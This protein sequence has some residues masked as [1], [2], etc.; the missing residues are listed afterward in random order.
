[1]SGLPA[2]A[3]RR[4]ALVIFLSATILIL[5]L[6]TARAQSGG[7]IEAT[8]TGGAHTIQG[9]IYVSS[10]QSADMRAKVRLESTNH[11][12]VEG[13][14]LRNSAINSCSCRISSRISSMLS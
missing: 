1:M 13:C 11:C 7:G 5:P 2:C 10:G 8:G 6:D 9:R 12:N 14:C 4:N 3:Q